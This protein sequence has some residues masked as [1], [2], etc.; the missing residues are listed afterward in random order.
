MPEQGEKIMSKVRAFYEALSKDE[1]MQERAKGL[2]VTGETTAEAAA[3]A[4]IAFAQAEGYA[5]T[6]EELKDSSKELSDEELVA[7]AGGYQCTVAGRFDKCTCFVYGESQ[8]FLCCGIGK[9][10][11]AIDGTQAFLDVSLYPLWKRY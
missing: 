4:V 5:F 10:I 1:A 6:A 8:G 3:E 11:N 9:A 7:V 2:K